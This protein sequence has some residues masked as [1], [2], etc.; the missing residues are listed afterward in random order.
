MIEK[1]FK[2]RHLVEQLWSTPKSIMKILGNYLKAI[3][4]TFLREQSRLKI[5]ISTDTLK[6]RKSLLPILCSLMH[7]SCT[8]SSMNNTSTKKIQLTKSYSEATDTVAR[9]KLLSKIQTSQKSLKRLMQTICRASV[10]IN[11]IILI[12]TLLNQSI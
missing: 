12:L 6:G 4:K 8:V 7:L 5:V 3:L 11:D 9:L 2:I 10:I 1:F